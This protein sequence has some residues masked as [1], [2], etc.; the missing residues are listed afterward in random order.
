MRED[1]GILVISPQGRLLASNPLAELLLGCPLPRDGLLGVDHSLFR[2]L[3]NAG[4]SREKILSCESEEHGLI[5]GDMLPENGVWFTSFPL[6]NEKNEVTGTVLTLVKRE[7]EK[8]DQ[9]LKFLG[10]SCQSLMD[11]LPEGAFMINT[12]WQ[13]NYFNE[14][15]ELITG[16]RRR[17]VLGKF[18]W[19]VFRSD[20]CRRN[21]PMRISMNTSEVLVDQEVKI[22]S[23][24]NKPKLLIV[25][26]SQVKQGTDRILGGLQTFHEPRCDQVP[27]DVPTFADIIAESGKMKDIIHRLS[28]VAASDSNVLI[29]GDSGTGKELVAKAIHL[30]SSRRKG[31]FLA[32]NCSA[33]PDNLLES[34]LFG[35]ERGAFTGA[36]ACKP[37]RFELAKG[38]TLF[39]DEIGDLQPHFQV[40]LLRVLENRSFERVGGTREISLEARII[41]ATNVDLMEAVRQGRFR[42]DLYYRLFTVPIHIPPLRERRGDIPVLVNHFVDKMNRKFNKQVRGVD[43]K[44][45]AAFYRHS[46]PGNVRE[47]QHI[48]EH[49][50][51]FVRGPVITERHLPRFET[52]DV[53]RRLGDGEE[54]PLQVVERKT[55]LTALR[56]AN[57]NKQ[58][59][60]KLLQ[61]SRSKLWRK[62]KAYS[63]TTSDFTSEHGQH[64]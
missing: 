11:M 59:A 26:T 37:G 15:A 47:L 6:C 27:R 24:N 21:C 62:M 14:T 51:V 50:F 1:C 12:R 5:K 39:L 56:T 35:H 30:H 46:W 48:I 42:E 54:A 49:C 22:L 36:V 44:V 63:I 52:C 9:A 25:N 53:K 2:Y 41:A 58:E 45:M 20:M 23:K 3:A 29:Q 16:F 28:M 19:E 38:G 4:H 31:P 18:C 7:V 10:L 32:V 55:I 8:I 60:A 33:I 64:F 17:E 43:P 34:E 61:I 13:I 40:K 57:G